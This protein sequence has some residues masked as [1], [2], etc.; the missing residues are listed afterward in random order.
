MEDRDREMRLYIRERLRKV[1]RRPGVSLGR[2]LRRELEDESIADPTF[3]ELWTKWR[4]GG[5]ARRLA[6][7]FFCEKGCPE[8]WVTYAVVAAF[9]NKLRAGPDV[10]ITRIGKRWRARVYKDGVLSH[11]KMF[12]TKEEALEAVRKRR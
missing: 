8:G 1:A 5:K 9:K 2:E 11:I 6:P 10:G 3:I 4:R 12:K 7:S